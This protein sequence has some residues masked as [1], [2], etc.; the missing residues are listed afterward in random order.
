MTFQVPDECP[1]CRA[2]MQAGYLV[3]QGHANA[4]SVPS[5]S[6]GEPRRSFWM[7]LKPSG[8]VIETRTWRCTGC[9]YLES[10]AP[11]S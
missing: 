6:E 7:G 3:D 10:Y 11:A 9:G 8:E 2:S 1:K 4:R 5:W